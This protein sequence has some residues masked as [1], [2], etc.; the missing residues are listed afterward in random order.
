[1]DINDLLLPLNISEV[2]NYEDD[3]TLC[4]CGVD[5]VKAITQLKLDFAYAVK[6]FSDN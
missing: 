4:V 3:T 5:I 6:L 2:C 1:M